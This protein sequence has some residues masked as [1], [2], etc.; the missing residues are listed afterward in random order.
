MTRELYRNLLIPINLSERERS[1]VQAARAL[2]AGGGAATLLHVIEEVEGLEGEEGE[3]FY[4]E[5]RERAEKRLD[6]RA[7]ALSMEGVA[8]RRLVV[9]GRRVQTI[10]AVAEEQGADLLV[11]GSAAVDPEHPEAGLWSTWQKVALTA[12][13]PVHLVR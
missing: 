10:L 7:T 2:L 3:R 5:L 9:V 12:H 11:M 8:L 6:E 4:A 13:C 1:V